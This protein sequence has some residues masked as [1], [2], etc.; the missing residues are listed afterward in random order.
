MLTSV[1]AHKHLHVLSVVPVGCHGG[2]QCAFVWLQSIQ[3]ACCT[4]MEYVQPL[5]VLRA[6]QNAPSF[7]R[8]VTGS[9]MGSSGA[10]LGRN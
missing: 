8:R 2:S 4:D 9:L 7:V 3:S 5:F 1:V 6:I 10:T